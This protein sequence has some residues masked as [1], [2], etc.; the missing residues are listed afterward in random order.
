MILILCAI[1]LEAKPFLNALENK[2]TEQYGKMKVYHGAIDG[3]Q[4]MVAC[5]GVGMKRA[6]SGVQ[7]LINALDITKIIVSGT[8]G[9][10]DGRLKVGDTV[11]S[12]ELVY[13][14]KF[15]NLPMQDRLSR[16]GTPFKAD[17]TML[18]CAKKSMSEAP[19]AHTVYFGRISTGN[20]FVTG[21]NFDIITEN[22]NP[23]CSEM[24]SAAVARVCQM[25][26]IPF[27]AVRSM[28]DTREVSGFINFF[29]YA[30]LASANS[31]E[32]VKRL[33]KTQEGS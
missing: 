13:H 2:T 14:E 15:E 9:G 24:E 6:A 11:V 12:E 8:A 30:K 33:L 16:E 3:A 7:A 19:P 29:K 18:G 26:G 22:F 17:D 25:S 5:C 20:S 4:V 27:I 1:K 32:V 21:K 31:F 28:S 23:L 10:I